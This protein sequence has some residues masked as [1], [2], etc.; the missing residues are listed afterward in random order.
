[1]DNFV[2][3]FLVETREYIEQVDQDL[4]TLEQSGSS[5]EILARVFRNFHSIK[6]CAQFLGFAKLSGVSHVGESLLS[7]LR[8]GQL[9]VTPEIITGML[10]VTDATREMLEQISSTG[11]DG[12]NAYDSLV[13]KIH[14]LE[15]GHTGVMTPA[16]DSQHQ[17]SSNPDEDETAPASEASLPEAV[18]PTI[19]QSRTTETVVSNVNKE[20]K[21]G[22]PQPELSETI[23]A[24]PVAVT[25]KVVSEQKSTPAVTAL[26][27]EQATSAGVSESQAAPPSATVG[28]PGRAE[29]QASSKKI[30]PG[31]V[32]GSTSTVESSIRVDVGL[33]DRLMTLVGELVLA[34][35]QILQ[36]TSVVNRESPALQNATQRLDAITTDLQEGMMKTRMQPIRNVWNSV[37]RV[38]RDLCQ[39]TG[40]RVRV[41]MEGELT[42]LDKTVLEAIKDPITHMVRNAVDHGVETPEV[43]RKAGKAEEGVLVMR[44]WHEGGQVNIELSDDGAGIDPERVKR[45]AVDRGI[46]RADQ[47]ARMTDREAVGLIFRPG[48]STA[49]NLTMISGRGVGM[50]VV[51]SSIEA[52]G[53]SVD[54]SSVLGQGST[55]KMR[56]PLTLAI[57]KALI[58]VARQERYAIPQV[59]L[60]EIIRLEAESASSAIET[61]HGVN[62]YR[63]RGRLLPIVNLNRAL[64]LEDGM[65]CQITDP[66][67][68]SSINIVILQA[69]RTLFGLVVDRIVDPQEIVVRP[70]AKAL[71]G[72]EPLA[73]ATIMGDGRVALILD[74]F[75]LARLTHVLVDRIRQADGDE[76]MTNGDTGIR[77]AE[78]I[79]S[80]AQEESR[81]SLLVMKALDGSRQAI[82]LDSVRRL[83][84]MNSE[85]IEFRNGTGLANYRGRILHLIDPVELFRPR[86]SREAE[87]TFARLVSQSGRTLHV[88]VCNEDQQPIGLV[89][90]SVVDIVKEQISARGKPRH[91]GSDCS[92]VVANQLTDILSAP[93]V[94][95]LAEEY[96]SGIAQASLEFND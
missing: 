91:R 67:E 40:K 44:A 73:G 94:L 52:I 14:L 13:S 34:R 48:F 71:R 75:G 89:F 92:A 45:K 11:K 57:L 77:L 12:E 61:L 32:S 79:G 50:D 95:K 30:S 70:L 96:F 15:Q 2:Q 1:M 90:E 88:V 18:E 20:A 39:M 82:A 19:T 7:K 22:Q 38:V 81:E 23:D 37:P 5:R 27:S 59:N 6:G 76:P 74:V 68:G 42:E 26:P 83:E 65:A 16:V 35:N 28:G 36:C 21:V 87:N 78:A 9:E 31:G 41:V 93:T 4:L 46:L 51:K 47:A 24:L 54:V 62:V 17:D 3:E 49:E 63:Y 60:V 58:I 72:I 69:D 66:P 84:V 43:R 8:E 85:S 25:A 86:K 56:I 55:M 29:E 33:L 80:M 53:G 64:G 10:A